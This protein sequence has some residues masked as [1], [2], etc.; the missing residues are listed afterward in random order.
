[1]WEFGQNDP[2][3]D[4]GSKLVRVGLAKTMKVGLT[5]SP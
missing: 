2:K 4:S 1:M 5:L 3:R